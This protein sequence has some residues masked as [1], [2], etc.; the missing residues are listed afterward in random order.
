MT[1]KIKLIIEREYLTK[2]RRKSFIVMSILGP[3]LFVGVFAIV[4]YLAN[5]NKEN[6][7]IGV[8]DE[9][10]LFLNAFKDNSE[11]NFVYYPNIGLENIIDTIKSKSHFG[12]IHI[13]FVDDNELD[14]LKTS[15]I[16][17]SNETP[18]ISTISMIN[19]RIER[20]I[21]RLKLVEL[22]TSHEIV[23]KAIVD[24]EMIYEN[25]SG[26][27]KDANYGIVEV[28]IGAFSGIMIY[29]FIFIYGVQVMRSVIEEKTNRIIEI[30][31]SSVKPFELMM[32][33]ILGSA[34]VGLTRLL[35]WIMLSTGLFALAKR[36]L[37]IEDPREQIIVD[38][39]GAE[40]SSKMQEIIVSLY[41][42]DYIFI[43]GI[44]VFFFIGG[45][46]LYSALFA[47]VGS[48]V[49]TDADTQQFMLP[50]TLP[51]II[52]IYSGIMVLEN[53]HGPV[54]FWLSMIPLTSPI[55]MMA[56][57]P[58]DVPMWEILLSM[59][60]LIIGFVLTTLLA[61]KI[62]RTGILMYG[63]KPSYKEIWKWIRHS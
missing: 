18:S 48:A 59:L 7:V 55:V 54:A 11:I 29:M 51:L 50:I 42:V 56:R 14:K 52:A 36:Y 33:K 10:S 37:G 41:E 12:L 2:V 26:E 43:F 17:F 34:L 27:L 4:A 8:Y 9:T 39:G 15:I 53:P 1:S 23:D 49:D 5:I 62:Y 38:N 16:F 13:P 35:L 21:R 32:G 19:R 57:I 28:A 24:V 3:I 60:F 6:K 30:V 44:F 63:K 46:L 20:K 25:F 58:F 61:A 22:G 40:M 47:A 45:Y 31:I